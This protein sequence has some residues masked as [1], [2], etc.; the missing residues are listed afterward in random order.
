MTLTNRLL[1]AL[2]PAILTELAP[3]MATVVLS[4]GERLHE[5]GDAIAALYFPL[6]CVLTLTLTMSDGA[7]AAI[8]LVGSREM[9]GLNAVLGHKATTQ[10]GYVVQVPGSAIKLE[11]PVFLAAFDRYPAVRAVLLRYTQVLIAQMAQNTACNSRHALAQRLARWLLEVHDRVAGDEVILTQAFLA[12]M[13]GA[14]RPSITLAAHGFQERGWLHY[15]RG[16]IHILQ[17]AGLEDAAC[18]CFQAIKAEC[19]RLLS[20]QPEALP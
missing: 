7:S 20:T 6:D 2:P 18:E 15:R 5:P 17:P 1:S 13:L 9:I 10:T 8:G 14:P 12:T 11:A 3:A 19:E 4:Q 16:H